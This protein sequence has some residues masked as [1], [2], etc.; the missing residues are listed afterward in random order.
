MEELE[1]E[2]ARADGP[3]ERGMGLGGEE[4][5]DEEGD[6]EAVLEAPATATPDTFLLSFAPDAELEFFVLFVLVEPSS[7]LGFAD[8]GTLFPC[9]VV[10]LVFSFAF[11]APWLCL[12]HITGRRR[13][14]AETPSGYY[15]QDLTHRLGFL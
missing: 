15:S 12:R 9:F 3:L 6:L 11:T 10:Y 4:E 2:L 1:L 8:R 14:I 13:I 7:E 5:D